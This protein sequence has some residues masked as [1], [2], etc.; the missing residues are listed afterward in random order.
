MSVELGSTLKATGSLWDT[1]GNCL[2]DSVHGT[3]YNGITAGSDTAY[4][5]VQVNVT[6][7]G[8]YKIESSLQDGF[9][10]SDSGFFTNTGLNTVR[11]KPLGTPIITGDFDFNI[12]FDSSFC[13]FSVTV[14]DSTGTGLG[15]VKDTTGTGG[16]TT[17]IQ[18][19]TWKYSANGA[20][21][22]GLI[23]SASRDNSSG[24]ITFIHAEGR[25]TTGDSTFS[26]DFSIMGTSIVPGTYTMIQNTIAFSS[27]DF[28]NDF[29]YAANPFVTGTDLTI[30]VTSYNATTKEMI[31]TFSGKAQNVLT[32]TYYPITNGSFDVIVP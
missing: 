31:G 3:F 14:N 1:S 15:G 28:L 5:D 13:T 2:P 18:T 22:S 19:G 8:S 4:V 17:Q 7:T 11:L 20:T 27:G 21:Y 24:L 9:L 25:G 23:D 10:F 30:I 12:S 6:A 26:L 32:S 16:D 29:S